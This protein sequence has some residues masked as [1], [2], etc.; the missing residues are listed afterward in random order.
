MKNLLLIPLVIF[1]QLVF[2]QTSKSILNDSIIIWEL[3]KITHPLSLSNDQVNGFKT[4]YGQFLTDLK[5]LKL[6]NDTKS[7]Y[8]QLLKNRIKDLEQMLQVLFTKNQ[9][10]Q[11]K[12]LQ[13]QTEADF[14]NKQKVKKIKVRSIFN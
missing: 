5:T 4:Y 3:R 1:S 7:E 11:Y 14:L 6:R 13:K 10:I 12:N 9:Y 2:S 8:P